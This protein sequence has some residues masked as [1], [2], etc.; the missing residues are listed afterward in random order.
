MLR[1]PVPEAVDGRPDQRRQQHVRRQV[2]DQVEQDL[3]PRRLGTEAEEQRARQRHGDQRVGGARAAT[4]AQA[5]RLSPGLHTPRD[6]SRRRSVS[7]ITP[8]CCPNSHARLAP[9]STQAGPSGTFSYLRPPSDVCT[10]IG[11]GTPTPNPL[12]SVG[13]A[14][15][16]R[17]H[18]PGRGG[19]RMRPAK[20]L[21]RPPSEPRSTSERLLP[22]TAATGALG[23]SSGR[24]DRRHRS[25]GP[26]GTSS[27]PSTW[28][29]SRPWR[30]Q[31]RPV[32]AHSTASMRSSRCF[33]APRAPRGVGSV[34]QRRRHRVRAQIERRI[35]VAERDE[36]AHAGRR[37]WRPAAGGTSPASSARGRRL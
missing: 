32:H 21:E 30:N 16:V 23:G 4:W 29:R 35:G 24:E 15:A 26:P 19:S 37:T 10:G 25:V 22:G 13:G 14:S 12:R 17:G 20:A 7:K 5:K 33:A 11:G 31:S 28:Q 2:D 8:Q 18:R 3:L 34:D 27:P 9:V 36:A 6:G 1:G